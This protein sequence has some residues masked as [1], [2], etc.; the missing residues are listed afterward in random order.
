MGIK[1]VIFD[2][3]GVLL[4]LGEWTYRKEV[5]QLLGHE[6]LPANYA[7]QMPALQRGE[8]DEEALFVSIAGRPVN[9]LDFDD[10]FRRY[11]KPI[12]EMLAFAAELR[13]MGIRTAIL[14]NTQASH[15]RVMRGMN[16]L[17]GFEP[18][19]MSCEAGVRKPEERAYQYVLDRLGLS[20]GEVAY[21]DD[22]VPFVE[23]G[24]QAGLQALQFTG[25]VEAIRQAVLA[26][27]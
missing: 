27:I 12:E 21:V 5:A 25:D 20:A 17:G 16:F 10:S 11:F 22:L 2:I 14:S 24:R 18:V 4:T 7:E 6:D 8:I 26:L 13:G 9:M 15:V 3:G 23:A 19:V 1:A